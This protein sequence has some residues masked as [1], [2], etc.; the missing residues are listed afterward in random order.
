MT[1]WILIIKFSIFSTVTV[2]YP[3]ED[4]CY[5]ALASLE[6]SNMQVAYCKPAP[7]LLHPSTTKV[8]I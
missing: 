5:K 8:S 3:S 7:K 4:A 1:S 6:Q 2:I